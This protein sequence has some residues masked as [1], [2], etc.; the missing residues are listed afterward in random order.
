MV[1]VLD[2]LG[3]RADFS[4]RK[5]VPRFQGGPIRDPSSTARLL[6]QAPPSIA[7]PW[8]TG[9]PLGWLCTWGLAS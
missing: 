9:T 1:S 5:E 4:Q 2:M 8:D 3:D 7:R 6:A